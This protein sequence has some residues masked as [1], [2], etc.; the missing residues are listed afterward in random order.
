VVRPRAG[1]REVV[2]RMRGVDR[3]GHAVKLRRRYSAC[4]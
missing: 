4:K 3:H 1:A 2:V